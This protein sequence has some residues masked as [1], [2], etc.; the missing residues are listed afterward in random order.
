MKILELEN[1][2]LIQDTGHY[3]VAVNKKKKLVDFKLPQD[4]ILLVF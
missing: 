2:P 1:S 3:D 4:L